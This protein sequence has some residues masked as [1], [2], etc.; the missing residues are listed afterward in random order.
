[1]HS[2]EPSRLEEHHHTSSGSQL[3]GGQQTNSSGGGTS[4]SLLIALPS[5]EIKERNKCICLVIRGLSSWLVKSTLTPKSG[6]CLNSLYEQVSRNKLPGF[7]RS[8]LGQQYCQVKRLIDSFNRYSQFTNLNSISLSSNP[9]LLY[10]LDPTLI[11][12][13]DRGRASSRTFNTRNLAPPQ[14]Q[15]DFTQPQPVSDSIASLFK[16]SMNLSQCNTYN[17][18]FSSNLGNYVTLLFL[19]LDETLFHT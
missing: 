15:L 19:V 10:M 7:L 3:V 6:N 9:N 1:M 14:P 5:E 8:P 17:L 12:E 13:V 16:A 18:L 4:Q 2:V 11:D